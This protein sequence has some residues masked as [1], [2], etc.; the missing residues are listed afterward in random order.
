M[1]KKFKKKDP[2]RAAKMVLQ[3]NTNDKIRSKDRINISLAE[4]NSMKQDLDMLRTKVSEL[5][6]I[7]DGSKI[8]VNPD[9]IPTNV[10]TCWIVDPIELKRTYRVEFDLTEWDTIRRMLY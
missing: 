4:Y 7:I 9:V 5:A 6:C 10:R 3:S 8:P 2:I 1:F